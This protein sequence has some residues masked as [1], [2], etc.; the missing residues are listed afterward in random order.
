M[1]WD[2][3][4]IAETLEIA[5][6]LF[7]VVTAHTVVPAEPGFYAIFV[8]EP[9]SL[10]SPFDRY[11]REK[12][13]RLI[14]TGVAS[15]SLYERLIEQDLRH[16][17]ASTFFRGIGAIL[18]YRPPSGSLVGKG[19]QNNYEFSTADTATIDAW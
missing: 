16:R 5:G 17:E 3:D 1:R 10:P 4:S 18:G 8:D 13:S 2:N 12:N 15:R 19:N 7:P 14:Y 6:K 9:E 11:L